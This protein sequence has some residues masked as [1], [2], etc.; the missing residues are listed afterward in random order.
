M[1]VLE[2]LVRR[3]PGVIVSIDTMK[4]EVARAAL[5]AGAAAVNDVTAFRHDPA[6]AEVAAAAGAG[7]ILMHSRGP[8]LELASAER[9]EYGDDAVGT[10]LGELR[11]SLHGAIG[12]GIPADRIVLDPG[13]GFAKTAEQS[14]LV[15]DQLAPFASLGRPLLVGP[16][17][18]RFL[19]VATGRDVGARD[20]ATAAACALAWERGARLFRVHDVAAARDALSLA[21]ALGGAAPHP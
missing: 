19:G 21:H 9:A 13:L 20:V 15:L 4:A 14:L 2:A 3:I 10:I 1:P 18:K 12:A 16:S 5:A 7:V 11:D 17:R 8:A 6:M